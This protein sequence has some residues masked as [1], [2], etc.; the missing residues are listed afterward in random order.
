[1]ALNF[2]ATPALNQVYQQDGIAYQWSGV[3]WRRLDI[4]QSAVAAEYS[5]FISQT[6]ST[7]SIEP[8]KYNYYKIAIDADT[9]ITLPAASPY[10]SF[11]VELNLSITSYVI[12]WSNNI[13]WAG[14]TAP[15]FSY[16]YSTSALIHF[17]TYNGVDW[18]ATP[19]SLD[20][21]NS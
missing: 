20:S 16:G 18:I 17:I 13:Q 10:S 15:S 2:P 1:M 4:F 7:V 12:T 9:T 14:G 8:D 5:D 6:S 21:R 11:V 3:K 19:L